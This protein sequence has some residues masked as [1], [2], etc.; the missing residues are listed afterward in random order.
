MRTDGVEPNPLDAKAF[1]AFIA[2]E[3]E[4]WGPVVRA[5]GARAD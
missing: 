1:H 3:I 5:S 4:R 2:A